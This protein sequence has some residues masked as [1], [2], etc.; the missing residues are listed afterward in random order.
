MCDGGFI[1]DG[2]VVVFWDDIIL[3]V[4]NIL[5]ESG[6]DVGKVLQCLVKKFVFKFIEKCWIEDEVK[7]FVKGFRQY[8]KNFFRIR[9]EL[10]FNKEIG[11]LI[12]FYYYWK[13]IFEVVSF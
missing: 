12:I 1:E 4:L 2:C 8:G 7:C 13:K 9:K 10:F 6:Y 11:E 3:N 5:Y